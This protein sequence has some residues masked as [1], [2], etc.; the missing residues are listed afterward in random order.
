MDLGGGGEVEG[1]VFLGETPE[2]DIEPNEKW[3]KSA[4]IIVIILSILIVAVVVV[5]ITLFFLLDDKSKQEQSGTE[6][7]EE[8]KRKEEEKKKRKEEEE[9]RKEEEEKRKE[10]EEKKRKEE[11]EKRKEEEEKKKEEEREKNK[12]LDERFLYDILAG[13]IIR[14]ITYADESIENTFAENKKHYKKEIGNV[15]EG[16][17]YKATDIN[18]YD[19]FLPYSVKKVKKSRGIILMIH[20]GA[21]VMGKKEDMDPYSPILYRA[22]Y[23]VAQ[24]D[25]TLL[26]MNNPTKDENMY[27]MVDEI[28]TC[29]NHLKN[30]LQEKYKMNS[31][32]FEFGIGGV[33]AGAHLALLY[34]YMIKDS[35][36][37]IKFILN[38][39]GPVMIMPHNFI[40]FRE[41]QGPFDDLNKID[42]KT[43]NKNEYPVISTITQKQILQLLYL[44]LGKIPEDDKISAM[45]KEGRA[46]E[47]SQDYKNL[48]EETKYF[49]PTQY[50]S[51]ECPPTYSFYAGKD[52][53]V[54]FLQYSLLKEAAK[55]YPNFDSKITLIYSKNGDHGFVDFQEQPPIS[56]MELNYNFFEAPRKY[57]NY[58]K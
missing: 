28:Y 43:L 31:E 40:M 6:T 50:I 19:L 49:F 52:Q 3:P 39:V 53:Y 29:I 24:M 54:G 18:K 34:S 11:E 20:G 25:Y 8:K 1:E 36:L 47:N 38:I 37:P 23:I 26:N 21:W 17:D 15:H 30:L 42:L 16:K 35:P 2:G 10:E 32:E 56:L 9:K 58:G 7:E 57:F 27:R 4:K 45:L 48:I 51:E 14:N 33:S 13:D 5:A 41:D 55:D 46:D 44:G 22:G 12:I